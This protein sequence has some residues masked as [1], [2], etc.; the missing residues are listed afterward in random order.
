MA[1]GGRE[2]NEFEWTRKIEISQE[3]NPWQLAKHAWLYS[4][5]LQALKGEPLNSA[6]CLHA[7]KTIGTVGQQSGLTPVR[8]FSV[9]KVIMFS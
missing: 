1:G 9:K 5:L 4:D 2:R 3:K 8:G 6:V 7:C